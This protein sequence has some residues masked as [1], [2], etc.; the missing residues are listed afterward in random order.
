MRLLLLLCVALVHGTLLIGNYAPP[1]CP[2]GRE[3]KCKPCYSRC[4]KLNGACYAICHL[5]C[6]CPSATPVLLPDNAT[7]GTHRDCAPPNHKPK[8]GC[9]GTRR[10]MGR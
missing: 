3:Y 9:A 2:E 1:K 10:A 4:D 6:W 5:G 8:G 7:C